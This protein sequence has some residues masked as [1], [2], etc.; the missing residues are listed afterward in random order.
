MKLQD[1]TRFNYSKFQTLKMHRVGVEMPSATA[2]TAPSIRPWGV[3][4]LTSPPHEVWHA[5]AGICGAGWFWLSDRRTGSATYGNM[6]PLSKCC[7]KKWCMNDT[8]V[9]L[10]CIA[11]PS[12]SKIPEHVTWVYLQSQ[13][14][15]VVAVLEPWTF[16]IAGLHGS[17]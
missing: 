13:K 9:K 11:D 12:A 7:A 14:M 16:Q 8:N 15:H 1:S 5:S 10:M 6:E 4:R 3:H 17:Q 2:P